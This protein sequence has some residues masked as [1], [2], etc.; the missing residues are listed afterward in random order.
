MQRYEAEKDSSSLVCALYNQLGITYF[1]LG[2][3]G[4]AIAN[5]R[6]AMVLAKKNGEERTVY[7]L[8]LNIV[9]LSPASEA[10]ALVKEIK[11]DPDPTDVYARVYF[12]TACLR[13]YQEAHQY[14]IAQKYCDELLAMCSNKDLQINNVVLAQSYTMA[15]AFFFATGQ[16][17]L[18]RKYLA[19]SDI[20][21]GTLSMRG[22]MS[23][24]LKWFK[25]DSAQGNYLDA[26]QHFQQFKLLSDSITNENKGRQIAQLQIQYETEKKDQDIQ[27]LTQQ[28]KLQKVLLKQTELTRN[29]T[30]GGIIL[31][32]LLLGLGFNRYRLKQRS[33]RILEERQKEIDEKNRSLQQLIGE[34]DGL[35]KEKEWLLKEIHHRVKNNLQIVMSLLNTQSAYLD[36]GVAMNAIRDSQHR[37]H[38]MSLIHQ[39]LYQTDNV[40]VVDVADY[41]HELVDYLKDCYDVQNHVRFDLNLEPVQLDVGQAVPLGLI[42]NE[43]ISN[44]VKYAFR[45]G[46]DGLI[47]ITVKQ[48]ADEYLQ[49]TISDNGAGLPPDFDAHKSGS[50]GMSLMKGLSSQLNGSFIIENNQGVRIMIEFKRE[51][52]MQHL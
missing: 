32:V 29:V 27:R 26:I 5:Y 16:Y 47:S 17:A 12:T 6:K 14:T 37:M 8:V 50:L 2:Q 3:K 49:L 35:L 10:L 48:Q 24:Q 18:A 30:I 20:F 34:K 13:A 38:S 39:K 51:K 44:A 21:Y 43:A 1:S 31:L 23:N 40:S 22:I 11:K 25:L 33:N 41:I 9:N 52:V 7:T 46:R 15:S 28:G 42:L 4:N 45:D 19:E 36:D